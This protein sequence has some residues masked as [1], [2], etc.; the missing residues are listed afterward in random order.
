MAD[1]VV[2]TIPGTD[3]VLCYN[4]GEDFADT[5]WPVVVKAKADVTREQLA[6]Y[7]RDLASAVERGNFI[8]IDMDKDTLI[9]PNPFGTSFY[10]AS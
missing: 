8:S 10:G 2:R 1:D 6:Q 5:L 9:E 4:K 7:L 3:T